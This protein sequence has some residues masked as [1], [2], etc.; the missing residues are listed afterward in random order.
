MYHS[1]LLWFKILPLFGKLHEQ[2]MIISSTLYSELIKISWSFCKLNIGS[3]WK[4]RMFY[5][6]FTTSSLYFF[7]IALSHC[8]II[9][10]VRSIKSSC[11]LFMLISWTFS[12]KLSFLFAYHFELL[13][14]KMDF[15]TWDIL[16]P[17]VA[18]IHRGFSFS[19]A[20]SVLQI[21]AFTGLFPRITSYRIWVC[22]FRFLYNKT[23]SFFCSNNIANW[24]LKSRT[25]MALFQKKTFKD[26]HKIF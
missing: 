11:F 23:Q 14:I 17:G 4:M 8:F 7:A 26:F 12:S 9:I 19:R 21:E 6:Q 1:I 3:L 5:A 15:T 24:K 25:D 20:L 22:F 16:R 18:T 13:S 10:F 2:L